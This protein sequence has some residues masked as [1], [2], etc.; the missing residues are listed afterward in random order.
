MP[1]CVSAGA[2]FDEALAHSREAIEV[3]LDGEAA[4]GEGPLPD[5][6]AVVAAG[7]AEVLEIFDEMRAAGEA[8]PDFHPEMRLMAV[9]VHPPV[10]V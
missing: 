8:P 9:E 7:V 1:G 5:T 4:S 2:T 6:P 3:W 10:A